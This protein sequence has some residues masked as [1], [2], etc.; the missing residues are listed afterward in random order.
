MRG[1]ITVTPC[2]SALV[3][4]LVAPC[5]MLAQLSITMKYQV[6]CYLPTQGSCAE[7]NLQIIS[8]SKRVCYSLAHL[9]V[10]YGGQHNSCIISRNIINNSTTQTYGFISGEVIHAT[11]QTPYGWGINSRQRTLGFIFV[12]H[13]PLLCRQVAHAVCK[14][15]DGGRDHSPTGLREGDLQETSA[16]FILHGLKRPAE[17]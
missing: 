14:G 4:N 6:V 15:A 7:T 11:A 2:R 8:T 16:A 1:L 17:S 10:P 13:L 12:E 3:T 9:P 5:G